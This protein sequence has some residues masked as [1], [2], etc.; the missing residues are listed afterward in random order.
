MPEHEAA[1]GGRALG[2]GVEGGG[3]PQ[4]RRRGVGR[5]IKT[6]FISFAKMIMLS[7]TCKPNL[8]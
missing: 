1:V 2:R 3:S 6:I 5:G 7:L 8:T 4:V